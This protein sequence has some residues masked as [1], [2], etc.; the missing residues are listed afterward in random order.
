MITKESI[1]QAITEASSL[2]TIFAIY[3]DAVKQLLAEVA[4]YREGE[5]DNVKALL[6]QHDIAVEDACEFIRLAA[7]F[8][9]LDDDYRRLKA[10]D[11]LGVE[12]TQLESMLEDVRE[13]YSL[14]GNHV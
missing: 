12:P 10:F 9:D 3:H 5:L 6:V 14:L 8:E 11:D 1:V 2:E 7:K 4:E 13:A